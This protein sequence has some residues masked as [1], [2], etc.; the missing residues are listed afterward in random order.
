M[1]IPVY[2]PTNGPFLHKK[3]LH[4]NSVVIQTDVNLAGRQQQLRRDFR[5]QFIQPAGKS[6]CM[7]VIVTGLC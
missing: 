2:C 7:V 1:I 6:M 3:K 4:R 5:V